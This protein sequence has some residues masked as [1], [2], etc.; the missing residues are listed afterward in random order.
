MPKLKLTKTSIDKEAKPDPSGDVLYWD[1]VTRGFGCRVTPKGVISFVAQGRV[2][3]TKTDR[4]TTIGTYGAWTVDD[5]RRKAEEYRHQLEDGVDPQQAKKEAEAQRVTL[6]DVATQYLSRPEKLKPTSEAWTRY[7]VERVYSDWKDKPIV[8]ITRDMVRERHAKL[9]EGGL[10]GLHPKL[11][12]NDKRAARG[13]PST[14]NAAMV[15][16]RILIEFARDEYRLADGTPVIT[17]NPVDAMKRHWAPEGDKSDHNIPLNKVGEVWNALHDARA[18]PM[19][20]DALAG[21]DLAIMLLLTGCRRME[22]ASLTWDRVRVDHT[23]PSQS[24]FHL[25][26]PKSGR[27]VYLP[28]SK[29]AVALLET[30]KRVPSNPHVFPSRGKSGHIGDPRAPFE[31]ISEVAGKHL[32]AH[33]LR[34]TFTNISLQALLIEKFRTDLLT[35]HVAHADTTVRHYLDTKKLDWLHPE[36]QRISDWIEQAGKVAAAKAGG[37]SVVDMPKRA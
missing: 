35:Q 21:I 7:Y 22:M 15:V 28:L 24:W 36:T 29:Q 17:S 31:L 11:N 8:S 19:P 13:A 34:R 6:G 20:D 16:L 12:P 27:E 10:K 26:D 14:A 1:T 5:A 9:V 33:D 2:K 18:K 23:D 25:P 37:G 3:G 30:R 4:R 32:T